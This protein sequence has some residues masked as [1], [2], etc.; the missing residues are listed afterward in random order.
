LVQAN[1]RGTKGRNIR[2]KDG[3]RE[4]EKEKDGKEGK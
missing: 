4:I 2:R 1:S 3:E